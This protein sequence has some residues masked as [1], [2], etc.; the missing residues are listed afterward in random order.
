MGV[1]GSGS[2]GSDQAQPEVPRPSTGVAG[3]GDRPPS[4]NLRTLDMVRGLAA[5]SV[6][7]FHLGQRTAFLGLSIPASAVGETGV[8]VFFVLSGYLIATS[9]LAP[10]DFSARDYAWKR[11][12]RILPLYYASI[13][14]VLIGNYVFGGD[15]TSLWDIGA[16]LVFLH[17]LIPGY[18]TALSGVL[19]TLSIEM[20]F[21]GLMLLLASRF[22]RPGEGWLIALAMLAIGL[23][24]RVVVSLTFGG[25]PAQVLFLD[26]QLI[27]AADV[28][29]CGLIVALIVHEG[30]LERWRSSRTTAAAGLGVALVGG[31]VALRIFDLHSGHLYWSTRPLTILFPF[32]YALV[33]ALC[34][35]CIVRFEGL[36]SPAL[37]WSG[38]AVLGV[39]SYSIYLLHPLVLSALYKSYGGA[40][41]K[42][43]VWVLIPV[44]LVASLIAAVIGY[45]LIEAPCIR[46][47]RGLT[48]GN[49]FLAK[50]GGPRPGETHVP[51]APTHPW[52]GLTTAIIGVAAMATFAVAMAMVSHTPTIHTAAPMTPS[53]TSVVVASRGVPH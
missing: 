24:W 46:A 34:V 8:Q 1:R 3:A 6:V 31:V 21:Y 10:R 27:G 18:Q 45:R 38:V 42:G 4:G 13:V 29:A 53:S 17:G 22:R 5:A 41:P 36:W 48:T 7:V 47:R 16:H 39:I 15:A 35:L 40:H 49:G 51:S 9:I 52:A 32:G 44:S 2:A 30:R 19:W 43:P 28:F 37:R 25:R 11:A 33:C 20:F 12:F 26:T 14:A 23:T 50:F